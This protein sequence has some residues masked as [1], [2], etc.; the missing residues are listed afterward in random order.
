[1]VIEQGARGL[2]VFPCE[3]YCRLAPGTSCR[4]VWL[5]KQ[6]DLPQQLKGRLQ[7]GAIRMDGNPGPWRGWTF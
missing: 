3:C 5:A 4:W 7:E 2:Q 1:M 6:P